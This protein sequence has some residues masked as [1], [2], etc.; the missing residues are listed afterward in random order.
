M[1][2][3]VPFLLENSFAFIKHPFMGTGQSVILDLSA[4]NEFGNG[5]PEG[6]PTPI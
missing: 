4:L 6:P 1:R 2:L 5:L 3:W